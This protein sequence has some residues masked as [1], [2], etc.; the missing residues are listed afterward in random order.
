MVNSNM[1]AVRTRK[2]NRRSDFEG[3]KEQALRTYHNHKVACANRTPVGK[4]KTHWRNST[5]RF[6]RFVDRLFSVGST[7]KISALDLTKSRGAGALWLRQT[8]SE[9]LKMISTRD[10][11]PV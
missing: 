2:A 5:G 9:N 8:F 3:A 11:R 10:G 4:L 6:G 1:H 7:P